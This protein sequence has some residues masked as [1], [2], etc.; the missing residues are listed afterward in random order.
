MFIGLAVAWVAA[1]PDA[2]AL[3]PE[4]MLQQTELTVDVGL[5]GLSSSTTRTPTGGLE[6]D[7]YET[8]TTRVRAEVGITRYL[9]LE[10]MV[11]LVD[12]VR[13]RSYGLSVTRFGDPMVGLAAGGTLGTEGVLAD[14]Q[15]AVFGELYFPTARQIISSPI[16]P[17]LRL[18]P[19][20][21]V[22][23]TGGVMGLLGAFLGYRYERDRT[24]VELSARGIFRLRS[25][26]ASNGAGFD[27]RAELR[28][29]TSLLVGFRVDGM[30]AFG[31]LGQAL[32]SASRL[33]DSAGWVDVTVIAGWRFFKGLDVIAAFSAPAHVAAGGYALQG[34]AL[35]SW[36]YIP[37]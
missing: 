13:S 22:A 2:T 35:L 32:I 17:E 27:A 9:K 5:S 37:K 6:R 4:R 25:N 11:P 20:G 8:I 12:Y 31:G 26:D 24:G 16:D 33:A 1:L 18:S 36:T 34:Q 10:L 21:I 28:V 15:V 23:T 30:F 3:R 19:R 14:L 29:F 7:H